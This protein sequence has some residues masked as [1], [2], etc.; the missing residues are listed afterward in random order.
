[1][2]VRLFE[3]GYNFIDFVLFLLLLL[4]FLTIT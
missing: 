1:M 3:N 4:I 2:F